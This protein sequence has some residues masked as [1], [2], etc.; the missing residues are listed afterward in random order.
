MSTNRTVG[1]IFPKGVRH[2]YILH[3]FQAGSTAHQAYYGKG[4]KWVGLENDHS[5]PSIAVVKNGG[6]IPLLAPIRMMCL[7]D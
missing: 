5:P 3:S 6:A 1:V 4:V 7:I 2:L